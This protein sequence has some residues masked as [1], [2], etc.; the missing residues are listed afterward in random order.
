MAT[1]LGGAELSFVIIGEGFA[2]DCGILG[3]QLFFPRHQTTN[4]RR[5][6]KDAGFE[7]RQ[8]SDAALEQ[9]Q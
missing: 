8:L 4:R 1:S 6:A 7:P 2:I 3:E 5:T 9:D